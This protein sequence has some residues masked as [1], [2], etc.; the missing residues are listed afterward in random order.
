MKTLELHYPMIQFLINRIIIWQDSLEVN[1]SVLTGS[2][3]VGIL[4]Y[5]PFPWKRSYAVYF[6]FFVF[7]VF[8]S[9]Q[10]Q[11]TKRKRVNTLIFAKKL[12]AIFSLPCV[13]SCFPLL[14]LTPSG[15]FMGLSSTLIYTSELILCSTFVFLVLRGTTFICTLTFSSPRFT[16]LNRPQLTLCDLVA[17]SAEWR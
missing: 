5:G 16:I 13:V 14:G 15:L 17:Q 6:F 3:L 4:P 7:I 1:P 2:F 12:P 10:I 8:K 9:R 11:T